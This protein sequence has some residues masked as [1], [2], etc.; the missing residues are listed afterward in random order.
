MTLHR[1]ISSV[2]LIC[3]ASLGALSIQ[4]LSVNGMALAADSADR[5]DLVEGHLRAGWQMQGGSHMAALQLRLKPDWKTY[6]RA[7]GDAGIPPHFDWS[8]SQNVK[9]VRFHWP[10]PKVFSTNG[11]RSVGYAGDLM[12]PIEIVPHD[13]KLPVHLKAQIDLGICKDICIP[14]SLSLSTELP[15]Q[16]KEDGAIRAALRAAP[17]T[18][19]AAGL[20][21]ITCQLQPIRDGLRL[22]AQIELPVQGREE[23]VVFEPPLPGVW[24]SEAQ[25][26][27]QGT[28]LTATADM[29]PP[30]GQP[31]SFER[32]ALLVTVIGDAGQAVEI[33]GCPSS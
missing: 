25:V 30:S 16:G 19:Q 13:P 15:L 9:S 31:F 3:A 29:V 7:P 10:A 18:A 8:G 20:R 4:A 5:A 32:S 21:K 26:S 12:L 11:M 14:A 24:V 33:K 1:L 22:T 17:A 28:T 6:W 2:A 23:M 27:R